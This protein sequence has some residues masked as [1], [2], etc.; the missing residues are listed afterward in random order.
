MSSAYVPS[1]AN[2]KMRLPTPIL[3]ALLALAARVIV[4]AGYHLYPVSMQQSVIVDPV[5]APVL[6]ATL[7]AG[8]PLVRLSHPANLARGAQLAVGVLPPLKIT[9]RADS[10][11]QKQ[12]VTRCYEVTAMMGHLETNSGGR[13]CIV[14]ASDRAPQITWQPSV[15]A[16][17]YRVYRSVSGSKPSMIGQTNDTSYRDSG[18]AGGDRRPPERNLALFIAR[19]A[20]IDGVLLTL[21]RNAPFAAE[22]ASVTSDDAPALQAQIDNAILSHQPVALDART[23]NLFSTV[24]FSPPAGGQAVLGLTLTGAGAGNTTFLWY[25]PSNQSIFQFQGAKFGEISGFMVDGGAALA[26]LDFEG[27][28]SSS[29]M[30]IRNLLLV[31]PAMFSVRAGNPSDLTEVSEMSFD[32]V[33]SANA[34]AA[35][36]QIEGSN[37]LN[38][39][40]NNSGCSSEPICVSNN[41]AI[42]PTPGGQT[43]GNFNWYG[44]SVSSTPL[45]RGPGLRATFVLAT[46]V[47][48][49]FVGV[50]VENSGTLIATPATSAPVQVNWIGGLFVNEMPANDGSPIINYQAGGGFSSSK[51]SWG[52]AGSFHF[53]PLTK[54]AV[55]TD[56]LMR[57]APG[58]SD[59]N[60]SFHSYFAGIPA[61]VPLRLYNSS[62][63]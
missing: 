50:R 40:F 2:N 54:A 38:F 27:H 30:R 56:D 1:L 45:G 20:I 23:Y 42:D 63:F 52:A 58:R 61:T 44:G 6:R 49:N 51:S 48:Y 39:N 19:V 15:G 33:Y 34:T 5:E 14:A 41:P 16:T 10:L 46:G 53:G 3:V 13:S 35:G 62:G 18:S 28:G 36:F 60:P 12:A 4:P 11:G 55:F 37:N 25:G 43:G 21:D 7:Q 26:D 59:A 32:S 57:V 31:N 47:P 22:D 24:V 29:G 17:G 9:A 8:H